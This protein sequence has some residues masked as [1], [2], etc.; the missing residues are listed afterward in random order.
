MGEFVR[1]EGLREL[2]AGNPEGK[3]NSTLSPFI[4]I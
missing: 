4:Q 1:T 2:I 3:S